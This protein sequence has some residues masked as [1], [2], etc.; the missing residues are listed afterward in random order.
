MLT[1]RDLNIFTLKDVNLTVMPGER[2]GLVGESGSGKSVTALSVMGLLSEHPQS[3]TVEW[4]GQPAWRQ[5]G[6]EITMVFQDPFTALNPTMR[7]GKQLC[8]GAHLSRNQGVALLRRVGL[9]G[10][11]F[12]AYPHELSG[13][14]RQ[15]VAI[16]IAAAPK[17]KLLIADEPTT[18]LDTEIR[19]EMM[20]L[21]QEL[22][23]AILL[24]SHDL[25][26]VQSFC[27]RTV[28][29]YGGQVMEEFSDAP[30][31]PYTLALL[32][33]M[34]GN[35]QLQPIPGSPPMG[36]IAGCPFHP[37]CKHATEQCSVTRP[38]LNQ[39]VACWNL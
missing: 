4:Q 1:I 6:K 12:D 5:R 28:V 22:D 27:S 8:E 30:K 39:G 13:G 33:A 32:D 38:E 17:P 16:G 23:C 25:K 20:Q 37:R 34:P 10:D 29:M 14:M 24:I 31:H 9:S 18:A 2:V 26:M 7:I 15:R 36:P 35:G 19:D 3:G 21:L 11:L